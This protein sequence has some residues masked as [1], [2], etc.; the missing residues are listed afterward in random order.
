MFYDQDFFVQKK[1]LCNRSLLNSNFEHQVS[2]EHLKWHSSKNISY[3][4]INLIRAYLDCLFKIIF[5]LH[6]DTHSTRK[7]S[8][9]SFISVEQTFKE[10]QLFRII[11]YVPT[12]QI[13]RLYTV[14][15]HDLTLILENMYYIST[16]AY[17]NLTCAYT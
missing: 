13:M 16:W 10:I 5:L 17:F 7:M 15:I 11:K 2:A 1:L 9:F 3:G 12:V 6:N 14:D 8:D 4:H